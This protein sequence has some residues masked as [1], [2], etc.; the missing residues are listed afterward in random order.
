MEIRKTVTAKN[1][2]EERETGYTETIVLAD[3]EIEVEEI[4]A[5]NWSDYEDFVIPY[6]NSDSEYELTVS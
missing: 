1:L 4:P 6:G 3:E 5:H 2:T